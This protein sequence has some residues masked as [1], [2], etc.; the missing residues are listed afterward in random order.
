MKILYIAGNIPLPTLKS[1]RIVLTIAE[2]LSK[3]CD[4]SFVF[5]AA[6]VFPPFS[7]IKKYKHIVNMKS[8]TDGIFTVK[9]VSY[10]R[11]P[12]KR[13][14]YL[15]INTVCTER[16]VEKNALP[17]LC[18]AHFIMPDGY[19]ACKIK[20]KYGVPYVVSVRSSDIRHLSG[21]YF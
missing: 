18:N 4:I 9:P 6:I 15:L 10:L 14:S 16:Y 8:W 12:G 2:K 1:N 21:T 5:P 17:D 13:L 3:F 7:F 20:K 19:I 11:L